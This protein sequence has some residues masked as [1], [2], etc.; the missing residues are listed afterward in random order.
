M[1]SLQITSFTEMGKPSRFF[2]RLNVFYGVVSLLFLLTLFFELYRK[3]LSGFF[4]ILT[5][6]FYILSFVI[7]AS[8]VTVWW[9]KR[10]RRTLFCLLMAMV[11]PF[12]F[13]IWF[14]NMMRKLGEV[15]SHF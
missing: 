11:P 14:F 2:H 4:Q 12:I 8:W 5:I 10:T 1:D 7:P 3:E 13:C 6:L 9:K 15:L